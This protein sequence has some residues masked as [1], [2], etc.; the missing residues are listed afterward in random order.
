ML[1]VV[2]PQV[3]SGRLPDRQFQLALL[4]A[5]RPRSDVLWVSN[6]FFEKLFA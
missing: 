2:Q 6:S 1:A 5:A 3:H 4:A